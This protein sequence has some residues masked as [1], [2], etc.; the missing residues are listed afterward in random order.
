MSHFLKTDNKLSLIKEAKIDREKDIQKL[1]ENN[2]EEVLGYELVTSEFQINNLRI[3]TLAYNPETKSFVIIEYKRNHSFSVIDQ[4]YAYLSILLNNKADFILEYFTKIG[5]HLSKKDVDWSQSKVVF[6]ANSFTQHQQTAINFKDLPIELWEF[7]LYTNSTISF[8]QLKASKNTE[9]ITAISSNTEV[10][11]IA[12]EIKTYTTDDL[13]K[14][15]WTN[16]KDLYEKLSEQ[17]LQIDSRIEENITKGYIGYKVGKT[18]FCNIIPYKSKLVIHLSRTQP[19][20]LQDP[21]KKVSHVKNSLKY[22]GQHL[23]EL[24]ITSEDDFFYANTIIKQLF[25]KTFTD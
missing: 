1:V 8:N 5:K 21:E 2:L 6:V 16:S 22:Y 9:S 14:K 4:G 20:D 3:D 12:R 25:N 10:K 17:I 13:F 19:K 23:S 24:I 11:N 18:L 7:K 15:D